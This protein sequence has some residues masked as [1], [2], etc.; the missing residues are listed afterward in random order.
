[1]IQKLFYPIL[2]LSIIFNGL[3]AYSLFSIP[4]PWLS[5]VSLFTLFCI[6]FL[7]NKKILLKQ[8]K[9]FIIFSFYMIT[10]SIFLYFYNINSIVTNATTNI[11]F[12]ILLRIINVFIFTVVLVLIINAPINKNNLVNLIVYSSLLISFLSLISYFSYIFEYSDFFRNR[13]GTGIGFQSIVK[14]CT[15]LRNYGTFR[16]PSFLAVWISPTIP[17]YILKSKYKKIWNFLIFIPLFSLFLTRSL[18]GVLSLFISLFIIILFSI[19]RNKKIEVMNIFPV[20]L[21]FI[22][23]IIA[24]T[25]SYKFPPLDPDQCPPYSP[26]YCSCEY[27]D[28]EQDKAKNSEDIFSSL[29]LRA[30]NIIKT[31]IDSFESLNIGLNYIKDNKIEFFGKGL[32]ISNLDLSDKY[33]QSKTQ[34]ELTFYIRNGVI[35]ERY[36]NNIVSFNNLYINILISTGILGLIWFILNLVFLIRHLLLNINETNE[37]TLFSLFVILIMYF[38]QAEEFSLWFAFIVGLS[39]LN[40]SNEQ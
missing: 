32:G 29:F 20:I 13:L 6:S 36:S 16:E 5:T 21:I 26:D 27:Y 4:L 30:E 22:A 28:D 9:S 18:T 35:I 7:Q 25:F 31:G 40:D 34:S 38:F 1:M 19:I 8:S 33:I 11:D 24:N 2:F 23:L 17:F 3:D 14:A 15:V 39:Y 37:A 12:Y 10:I